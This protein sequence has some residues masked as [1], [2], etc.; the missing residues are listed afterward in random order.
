METVLGI[1]TLTQEQHINYGDSYEKCKRYILYEY[2][3]MYFDINKRVC[4]L[5]NNIPDMYLFIKNAYVEW[6]RNNFKKINEGSIFDVYQIGIYSY[7]P[8]PDI[9]LFALLITKLPIINNPEKYNRII[10]LMTQFSNDHINKI[11]KVYDDIH[12]HYIIM[13]LYNMDYEF[14][15]RYEIANP[16]KVLIEKYYLEYQ[17]IYL[18]IKVIWNYNIYLMD[19]S[20][21]NIL[22]L[23]KSKYVQLCDFEY[24]YIKFYPDDIDPLTKT[25]LLVIQ[26][27][28]LKLSYT[29]L[30]KRMFRKLNENSSNNNHEDVLNK[31]NT[32]K[33]IIQLDYYLRSLLFSDENLHLNR[34]S[35]H[36]NI[37]IPLC[38]VVNLVETLTKL[39]CDNDYF[40]LKWTA[41]HFPCIY[42]KYKKF[43]TLDESEHKEYIKIIIDYLTFYIYLI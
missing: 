21:K 1:D 37:E 4:F 16:E 14:Y 23:Y 8:Y 2:S 32:N 43:E 29:Y 30:I 34:I 5:K 15:L 6:N 3:C 42:K 25:S 35:F 28:F 41:I 7:H 36:L 27:Y 12:Y 18:L 11:I 22:I 26:L 40:Y 9:N 38:N 24:E 31:I 10:E 33:H 19:F 13:D 39:L 20:P 17:I